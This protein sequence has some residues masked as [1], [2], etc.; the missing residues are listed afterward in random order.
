MSAR[1]RGPASA[2]RHTELLAVATLIAITAVWGATFVVVKDAIARM[3]VLDFLAWRFGIATVAMLVLRP[4]SLASL[5]SS[6]R[7]A[8]ALL[9]VALGVG[10]VAQTFGLQTTPASVSGFI[11]GMFVAFTPVFAGLLL[12]RRVGRSAWGAVVL[13]TAGLA[14]LALR[15]FAIGGGEA[16][17]LACAMAFALH[18]VGLGEWSSSYDAFGL[19]VVQLAV[20]T[21]LCAVVAVPAGGLGSPPDAGVWAALALTAV[22]A[23]ALAFVGQTWAQGHLPPARAAVVLTM[24]PVFAGI[25]GVV[26]GGDRLGPRAVAGAVL[27]IGAMLVA[28]LGPRRGGGGLPLG[29]VERLEV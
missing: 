22:F 7:R 4:R 25:F 29:A 6:G 18:I 11:T 15:G 5:P 10:Y 1:I 9:G 2:G 8:G 21:V 26:V 28:E 19:A 20:V 27:V 24:E 13:A 16:L 12:R 14:L 17:T 23:T 3:P